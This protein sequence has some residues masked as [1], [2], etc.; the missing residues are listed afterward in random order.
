MI[1]GH[2]N[3]ALEPVEEWRRRGIVK[4]NE[5]EASQVAESHQA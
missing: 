5:K 4:V 3:P 2:G 1:G